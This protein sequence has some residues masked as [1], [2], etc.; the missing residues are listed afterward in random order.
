MPSSSI[1]AISA[2]MIGWSPV[3]RDMRVDSFED[4]GND[5]LAAFVVE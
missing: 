1:A 4:V 5:D 2:A 3:I